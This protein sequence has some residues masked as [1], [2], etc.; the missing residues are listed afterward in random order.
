[1]HIAISLILLQLELRIRSHPRNFDIYRRLNILLHQFSLLISHLEK[2]W[3]SIQFF[4][5]LI[6]INHIIH[7]LLHFLHLLI[8]WI[9]EARVLGRLLNKK[10]ATWP[11]LKKLRSWLVPWFLMLDIISIIWRIKL[12]YRICGLNSKVS[13]ILSSKGSLSCLS[14]R[15]RALSRVILRWFLIMESCRY[16]N[17]TPRF[18]L[19][20][21]W[22]DGILWCFHL[23]LPWHRNLIIYLLPRTHRYFLNKAFQR[24]SI[25]QTKVI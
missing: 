23:I 19:E 15:E 21:K 10:V 12:F 25:L 22:I 2:P 7:V 13:H 8:I 5:N 20:Y 6:F 3:L 14:H 9:L 1:M 4:L 18:S 16:I 11:R 24:I 17:L